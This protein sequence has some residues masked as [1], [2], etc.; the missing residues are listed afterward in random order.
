[1]TD[2]TA[3]S[4]YVRRYANLPERDPRAGLRGFALTALG[5]LAPLLG[6]GRRALARPR[7]QVLNLHH[8]FPDEEAG[9]RALLEWLRRTGHD[10]VPYGEGVRALS[11]GTLTRPSV[12]FTFDD[13]LATCVR[14]AEILEEFGAVGCCFVVTSMVGET[15]PTRVARFTAERIHMPPVKFLSW[16]D[17]EWLLRRGHEV[18]SHTHAH[19]MVAETSEQ[20]LAEDLERSRE[21]LTARCGGASHFSWPYGRFHHF[22]RAGAEAVFAAGFDTCASAERGAHPPSSGSDLRDLCIRRDHAI[23]AWPLS[24][25]RWFIGNAVGSMVPEN[26]RWPADLQPRTAG[27]G[28]AAATEIDRVTATDVDGTSARGVGGAEGST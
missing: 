13:G 22:S 24:H 10:L 5:R 3:E 16:H 15:D 19:L 28:G 7:L 17:V 14:A 18:G 2:A 8:V 20:A 1:M 23:A 9:F 11:E 21:L 12:A 25:H 27:V 26:S 4:A 6:R